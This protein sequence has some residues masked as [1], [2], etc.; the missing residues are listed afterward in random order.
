MAEYIPLGVAHS[1]LATPTE[2]IATPIGESKIMKDK[3]K[4]EGEAA[5]TPETSVPSAKPATPILRGRPVN[6]LLGIK[7]PPRAPEKTTFAKPVVSKA[8]LAAIATTKPTDA[9]STAVP[10]PPPP[11][12]STGQVTKEVSVSQNAIPEIEKAAP[13]TEVRHLE[14]PDTSKPPPNMI[15]SNR[16]QL[17]DLTQLPPSLKSVGE[18]EKPKSL[19]R[20]KS[21]NESDNSSNKILPTSESDC[22]VG[23]IS[24][25]TFLESMMEAFQSDKESNEA[26]LAEIR[27][28]NELKEEDLK[29]QV[30]SV[31][32]QLGR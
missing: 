7:I 11:A 21:L 30:D 5:K 22:S 32:A 18:S 19:T 29:D 28:K 20:D 3:K 1:T 13:T 17:P 26:K 2:R 16:P 14:L 8:K 10:T 9:A 24:K 15:P 12:Q 31:K 27:K 4:L 25:K 6:R 23:D